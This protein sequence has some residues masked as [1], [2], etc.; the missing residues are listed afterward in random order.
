MEDCQNR[1]CV[2][3]STDC[4]KTAFLL[5]SLSPGQ[6][7]TR[8]PRSSHRPKSSDVAHR[9][10]ALGWLHSFFRFPIAGST[11]GRQGRAQVTEAERPPRRDA[12]LIPKQGLRHSRRLLIKRKAQA[13]C[14]H[15]G[16]AS[17]LF[18]QPSPTWAWPPPPHT[19]TRGA[20]SVEDLARCLGR[21]EGLVD[22]QLQ[23]RETAAHDLDHLHDQQ[24]QQ[25]RCRWT[26]WLR[27][28]RSLNA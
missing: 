21:E 14:S 6:T 5:V 11:P 4:C 2:L 9:P 8:S 12:R 25:Q 10:P 18:P 13:E 27:T 22:G 7:R 1:Q 23:G 26:W 3:A 17:S 20:P 24:Q 16:S 15:W 19:R 28:S